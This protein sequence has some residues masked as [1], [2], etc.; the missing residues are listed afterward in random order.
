MHNLSELYED[1]GKGWYGAGAVLSFIW[2]EGKLLYRDL[3]EMGFGDFILDRLFG[4]G[5][6]MESFLNVITAGLWPLYWI[7]FFSE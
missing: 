4:L 2:L 5:F 3:T 6:P 7:R 1:H